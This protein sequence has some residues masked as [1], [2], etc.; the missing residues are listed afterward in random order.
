MTVLEILMGRLYVP[1]PPS[2]CDIPT[3]GIFFLTWLI[4]GL[5]QVRGVDFGTDCVSCVIDDVTT[6]ILS[7]TCKT[8]AG[9]F[10]QSSF[11]LSKAPPASSF[12]VGVFQDV[13]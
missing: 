8:L 13:Y 9:V 10:Q 7:C 5:Q 11:N 2:L 12:S 6:G 4:F 3:W 1:S